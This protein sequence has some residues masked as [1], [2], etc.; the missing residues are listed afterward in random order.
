MSRRLFAA[1]CWVL[2]ATGLAHLVGHCSLMNAQG[3]TEAEK[4]LLSLMRGNPQDM[5]LGFVRSTFDI[6]A[7]FSLTFS[8]LP[9]GMGLL[10][11]LLLRHE[12][13][14]PG[15]LRQ[16][17]IV[18]AGIFGVMTGVAL[19]YWFPAPLFFLAAAFLCFVAAVA[20]APRT[21]A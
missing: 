12:G 19:R 5:G 17:A 18:H 2:V 14:A 9:I 15:L 6:L 10:G 16:A 7:G 13:V 21:G 3:D 20:T 4:Q 8:V 11:L 1:G